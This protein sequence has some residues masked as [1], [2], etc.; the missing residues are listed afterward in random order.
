M[1]VND[2][3]EGTDVDVLDGIFDES[4]RAGAEHLDREYVAGYDR[5]AGTDPAEDLAVLRDL[6]L[7]ESDTLIDLGAGTGTFALAAAPYCR[8][9]VA[10]DVSPV[11]L[12][13]LR[14]KAEQLGVTNIECVQG[15]FLSYRHRGDPA[16]FV[17]SRNALHHLP[18]FWKVLALER[19]ASFLKPGGVFRLLDLVF[20]FDPVDA[21]QII[22]AWLAGAADRPEIGWTRA[23]F[24]THLREECSTFS[25]LLEPMFDRT[26]FDIR[27]A[28]HSDSQI[29]AAYTCL[30]R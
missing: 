7:G 10:V 17:Y 24:E 18:D 28:T 21:P 14:M 9:V 16:D 4:A 15:G 22:A 8:L 23:E 6:G 19:I 1:I 2:R 13:V 20:S 26:G 3:P 25:W 27:E 5:K 11:M 29:Y 12:D 30:K